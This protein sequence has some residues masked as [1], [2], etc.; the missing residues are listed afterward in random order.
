MNDR[1]SKHNLKHSRT[2]NRARENHAEDLSSEWNDQSEVK[3]WSYR[4]LQLF[5]RKPPPIPSQPRVGR[6]ALSRGKLVFSFFGGSLLL[7][8]M[9]GIN[10]GVAYTRDQV[11]PQVA[12][13]LSE[14]LNR[15]IQLGDLEWVTP[16]G[17]RLGKSVIPATAIDADTVTA[18]AIEVQ[19]NPFDTLSHRKLGLT[20]TLVR[21]HIFV[22]QDPNGKWLATELALDG[23]SLVEVNQVRL[24][25]ATIEVVAQPKVLKPLHTPEA[26][27]LP[28]AADRATFYHINSDIA[29]VEASQQLKFNLSGQPQLGGSF[30][31]QGEANWGTKAAT[32][33]MKTQQL[34]LV[35]LTPLLPATARCDQGRLT[36]NIAVQVQSDRPIDLQGAANLRQLALQ[37]EGEPNL[38]TQIGG[39]FQFQGQQITVAKGLANY[40]Q[41]PFESISGTIDLAN[42]Q[43]QG[44]NLTGRVRSVDVA[45]FMQTFELKVPFA[46]RGALASTELQVTGP[47]DG[48]IY[49][50]HVIDAQPIQFDRLKMAG[51]EGQF[52]YDSGSDRLKIH[53]AKFTPAVGGTIASTADIVLGD[54]DKG[55]S[56]QVKVKSQIQGIPADAVAQLYQ[57]QLPALHLGQFQGDADISVMNEVP[58][59][60]LDWKLVQ[61][62]YPAQGRITLDD[63]T[64]RLHDTVVHVADGTL[65]ATG[66]L[67]QGNWQ[68]AAEAAEIP[69]DRLLPAS[70]LSPS[71]GEMTGNLNGAVQLT[72]R[73]DR[74]PDSTLNSIQGQAQALMQMGESTL[75]VEGQVGQGRWQ[76]QLKG[77]TL[78]LSHFSA[79]LPGHLTGLVSLQGDLAHLNPEAIEARGQGEWS[80]AQVSYPIRAAF[81]WDGKRLNLEQVQAGGLQAKGWVA[82]Q[83]AEGFVP[84]LSDMNLAVQLQSYDL[85]K[86]V[87][88]MKQA[89]LPIALPVSLEGNADFNGQV[90]GTPTQPQLNG[91]L[92]L[93]HLAVNQFSFEPKLAGSVILTPD[94]GANLDL[95]GKHD[96][97]AV[98]LD[99]AYR[100]TAL[101]VKQGQT[102]V[103]AN[104]IPSNHP[105][106]YRLQATIQ[107]FPLE[108]L[109]L[110]PIAELGTVGGLLSGQFDLDL[111]HLTAPVVQGTLAIDQPKWGEFNATPHPNHGADRLTAEVQYDPQ[112][113]ALRQGTLQLGNGQYHLEGTLIQGKTPHFSAQFQTDSG[114]LQDFATLLP[115]QTWQALIQ[116]HWGTP[117]TLLP[118]SIALLP[119]AENLPS[120]VD[121]DSNSGVTPN[122]PSN[123]LSLLSLSSLTLPDISQLRGN[124]STQIQLQGSEQTGLSAQFNLQG[125]HWGWQ[126]YSIDQVTIANGQWDGHQLTVQPLQLQGLRYHANS[127][128]QS[129][130]GQNA[131]Q[132]SNVAVSFAGK[133]G[134]ESDGH[135]KVENLP[136]ALLGQLMNVSLPVGGQLGATATLSGE[137]LNPD[138]TGA[139]ETRSVHLNRHQFKDLQLI[140]NYREG[141]FQVED[142]QLR[143]GGLENQ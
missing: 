80:Q 47:L 31:V 116:S 67:N 133:V 143:E 135:L 20:I 35:A 54:D 75:Q 39:E 92:Q 134:V 89:Q 117:A 38:F 55:E 37:V 49:S 83:F 130:Q 94:R 87:D 107:S 110:K 100:P 21:P 142:W 137:M 81:G 85:A 62:Q 15:P 7:S 128:A 78:P 12:H 114:S 52:T 51:F 58:Q 111:T 36:S 72:G 26:Q 57:T 93:H 29:I 65:Q 13:M 10:W 23:D 60:K 1:A 44:L 5:T 101:T 118:D 2:N 99:S 64:V 28:T 17:L 27:S 123:P 56:D 95:Q 48:A 125:Q 129:P 98:T 86:L 103:Q 84:T 59:V 4:Q 19:F 76:A 68:F 102:I 122:A 108:E 141:Q 53:Q 50:G 71:V 11:V 105:T 18:D 120:G 30:Q 34:N 104:T 61:G 8:G 14:S 140:F 90:T 63:E 91:T 109:A 121:A 113:L 3:S 131:V 33:K 97:I 88:V 70:L 42:A 119:T 136:M 126:Q 25:E 112:T 22:Q 127:A 6:F 132:D 82:A 45:A 9:T 79:S 41:I 115:N 43:K 40:G 16:T 69:V 32:L 24:Q 74:T 139:V 73:L 66:N 96:R 46:I 77:D 138:I 106:N 124:F